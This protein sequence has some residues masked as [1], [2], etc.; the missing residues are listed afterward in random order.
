M[1]NF[2]SRSK[3]MGNNFPMLKKDKLK[4]LFSFRYASPDR[5]NRI[6]AQLH[7]WEKD[8]HNND[9]NEVIK[10]WRLHLGSSDIL[11][12]FLISFKGGLIS[13]GILISILS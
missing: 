3:I 6:T 2:E 11:K 1:G 8:F 13:E 7:S 4:L 5:L 9:H 12:S 10:C